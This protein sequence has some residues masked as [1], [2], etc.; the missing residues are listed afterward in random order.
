MSSDTML[1][2][3]VAQGDDAEPNYQPS[4]AAGLLDCRNQYAELKIAREHDLHTHNDRLYSL[5]AEI[6]RRATALSDQAVW[7]EF[8]ASSE[9]QERK[10]P[11]QTDHGKAWGHAVRYVLPAGV[12]RQTLSHWTIPLETLRD[13]GIE[14]TEIAREIKNRGGFQGICAARARP[15]RRGQTSKSSRKLFKT[16]P[17]ALPQILRDAS[18]V[19][20]EDGRVRIED[21]QHRVL[22]FLAVPEHLMSAIRPGEIHISAVVG[23]DDLSV[24]DAIG[25]DIE[26]PVNLIHLRKTRKEKDEE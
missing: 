15:K 21:R 16:P 23:Q 17:S 11:R 9:W 26:V 22:F 18:A 7:R 3:L 20:A 19:T 13:E 5:A 1:V 14:A 12:S 6:F 10:R 24:L 25:I 8:V 2:E 4:A